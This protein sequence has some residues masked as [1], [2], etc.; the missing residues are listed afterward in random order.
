MNREEIL[1]RSRKENVDEGLRDAQNRGRRIGT[2][3]FAG[4]VIAAQYYPLYQFTKKSGYLM[5]AILGATA[6]LA[7]LAAYIISV[8][9]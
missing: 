6:S 7:F 8:V 9:M 3:A 4:M 5:S 1:A 2:A